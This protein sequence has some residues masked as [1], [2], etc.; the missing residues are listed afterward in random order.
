MNYYGE[1]S[2]PIHHEKG[3]QALRKGRVSIVGQTYLLTTTTIFRKPVF[4]DYEAATAVA[5]QHN[6]PAIWADSK[7]LAWV[8]MPDHWHG[9]VTLGNGESLDSLMR[10]FKSISARVVDSKFRLNAWLWGKGFHDRAIRTDE[11]LRDAARYVIA[12]PIRAGLVKSIGDY[13]YWD[14]VWL[15][16]N[17]VL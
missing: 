15:D 10:R 16:S 9:L 17:Y 6:N 5:R 13:S 14:A 3:H 12:N 4:L 11:N 1:P 8:L 7:C 2:V